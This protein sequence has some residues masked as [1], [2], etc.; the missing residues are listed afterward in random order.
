[1]AAGDRNKAGKPKDFV[2]H[3]GYSGKPICGTKNYGYLADSIS[4]TTC[5]KCLNNK[6]FDRTKI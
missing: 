3:F 6:V 2:R 1:M 5:K 4:D